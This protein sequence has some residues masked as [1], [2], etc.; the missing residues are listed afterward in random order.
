MEFAGKPLKLSI[1]KMAEQANA[2]VIGQYGDTTVLV[3]AVMGKTD[4]S[5]DYFP[6]TVDYEE[7]FYAAGKII[8]SRFVRREGRPSENAVLSGRM[9]DRT[10]RPLFDHRIR[11]DVQIVITVL[12]YDEQND[13]DFISLLTASTALMISDIPWNGPVA[14]VRLVKKNGEVIV[15]PGNGEAEDISFE[16]FIGTTEKR[17]NMIELMGYEVKENEVADAF[18]KAHEEIKKLLQF[19]KDIAAKIGKPKADVAMAE[20]DPE[21]KS[22]IRNFLKD[23]LEDAVYQTDKTSRNVN[24]DQVRNELNEYLVQENIVVP[25]VDNLFETEIDDLVHKNISEKNLRPDGRKLDEVRDLHAEVGLFERLHGSALFIRGGTQA[26]AVTTLAAPGSEQM[27]ETMEI[28]TKRRFMLHYNFPPFATGEVGR[29]G[30]PGRREIG[31]GA[32]AEKALR[33]LI[34]TQEEFPYTIRIVSE[35]L[36]SNG[37]SSMATVCASS[38]S[39]M[40]AGVPIKKP[41][42]GIAMGLITENSTDKY[43]IL[44]DIQGPE[45]HYGDMDCKVAGTEEG[46]TAIQMD[47]KIEGI[48]VR[49]FSEILE[50]AKKARLHILET[51]TKAIAKPRENVSKYAPVILT[52]EIRPDQIGEVIGSG[53]KVINSI[54]STSGATT[55][56]IEQDGKVYVA[57]PDMQKAQQAIHAIQSLTKEFQIGEIVEGTVIKILEFGAIVDIGGGR[58]G[59]IHVSELKEGFV[60]KVEDVVKVG[61]FVRAK[62]IKMEN[63]RIGLSMKALKPEAVNK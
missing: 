9:I 58:E 18:E 54:I 62:I 11:R 12:S 13:P 30:A 21:I 56:D 20:M 50:Q 4:R 19:Q 31:H 47:V 42:A 63:G 6:L 1:S 53:G 5:L 45:D 16:A 3:T 8:G 7:K 52:L 35:I 10:I 27:I 55:I 43:K 48:T 29:M 39:L 23:K 26:L 46:I 51:I 22:K 28:S 36:A 25:G 57:A 14:G 38:M 49:M 44:T 40:D 33:P 34:P 61:D 37:S 60:K 41:A 2:A 32:L 15:N 17:I 24:L 59:M